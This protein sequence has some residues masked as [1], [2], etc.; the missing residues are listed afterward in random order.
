MGAENIIE[1][2][3]SEADVKING[4]RPWDIHVYNRDLFARVMARGSLGLGEAYMDVWWDCEQL[5][6]LLCRVL[7]ANLG[8]R[9][10]LM[11]NLAWL[12]IK[13]RLFNRQYARRVWQVADAHYN[14]NID[15]FEATF[16]RRVTGSCGYWRNADNLDEAQEAKLDLV[17]RKIGLKPGQRVLDIGCGW[18]AFMGSAAE[19]YGAECVGV[20]VSKEQAAYAER[21]Y[22]GFSADPQRT[23]AILRA[24]LST[25]CRWA[26]LSMSG[27]RI[28]ARISTLHAARSLTMDCSCCTP[29]GAT[30][31]S[32]R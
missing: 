27:R 10:R 1:R 30:K 28:T 31:R 5:D 29:S 26:C 19:R 32:R 3:F 7:G 11:P 2:L 4:D 15:I 12:L 8:A 13:S 24:T 17:C 23:I 9:I 18:G 21:R 22:A 25:S 6:E 20:T 16:D 14:L